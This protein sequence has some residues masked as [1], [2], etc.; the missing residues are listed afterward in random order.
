MQYQRDIDTKLVI[1]LEFKC[2]HINSGR[3][4][5]IPINDALESIHVV[6]NT[7]NIHFVTRIYG[8]RYFLQP[9]ITGGGGSCSRRKGCDKE[10]DHILISA[11]IHIA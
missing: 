11:A 1:N 3:A 9:Q 5:G 2:A 7:I 10:W 8:W 4:V 6:W